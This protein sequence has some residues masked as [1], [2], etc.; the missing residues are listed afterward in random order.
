M[1]RSANGFTLME[2][3]IATGI[4][5]IVGSLIV[6]IL[7]NNTGVY[8]QQSAKIEQGVQLN[9]TLANIEKNIRNTNS[10]TASYPETGTP[11]YTTGNNALVLKT[12]SIDS[13]NNIIGN[14]FDYL[15]YGITQ[16][17]LHFRI[18]PDIKSARKSRDQILAD[19]VTSLLFEYLDLNNSPVGFNAASK[20]KITVVVNQKAGRSDN[21]SIATA[22]A[23]LKNI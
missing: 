12:L 5:A 20:V 11:L 23:V 18:Y 7:V 3:I 21:R 15:I 4:T 13:S 1:T 22:E 14:S 16:G 9:N 6:G 8:Y 2:V 10:I 19:N 17:H